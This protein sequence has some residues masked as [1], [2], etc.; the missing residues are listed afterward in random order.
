MDAMLHALGGIMLR[1]VPTFLLVILLHFY[2]KSIF[3]KPLQKV[4]RDRYDATEGARK[5]AEQSLA[6]ADVKTEQF[7]KA[8][9]AAKGG[10]YQE[11]E[12]A[13][14]A[15]QE[16]HSAAVAQA[17]AA[18]EAEIKAARK[19]LAADVAEVKRTL[20]TE[21]DGLADRIADSILRRNAA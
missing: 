8:L 3:F 16:Q 6:Q 10:V 14:K 19:A 21:S 12:K 1:A 18:A 13:F 17:R 20:D 11:Q 2:L 5:H 15:L 4:L 7:E 9:W